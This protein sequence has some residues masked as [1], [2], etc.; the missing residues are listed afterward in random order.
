MEGVIDF[1]YLA[2]KVVETPLSLIEK[3]L[4]VKA[5]ILYLKELITNLIVALPDKVNT[6][7]KRSKTSCNIFIFY[8]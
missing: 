2:S 1:K 3:E 6:T 4:N 8:P 5:N 7:I